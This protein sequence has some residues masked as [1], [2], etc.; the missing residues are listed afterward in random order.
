MHYYSS[1]LSGVINPDIWKK[2]SKRNSENGDNLYSGNKRRMNPKY[3]LKTK[4]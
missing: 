1:P 2:K 4:T 3:S